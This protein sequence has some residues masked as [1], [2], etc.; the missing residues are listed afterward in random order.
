MPRNERLLEDARKRG[1]A[2][3]PGSPSASS[4][5]GSVFG[6]YVLPDQRVLRVSDLPSPGDGDNVVCVNAESAGSYI[7]FMVGEHPCMPKRLL[8]RI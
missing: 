1:P 5:Y 4:N 2:G 6:E 7:E 8:S 3:P